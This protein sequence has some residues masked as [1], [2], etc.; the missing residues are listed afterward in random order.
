MRRR[1]PPDE[2]SRFREAKRA[3]FCL[4]VKEYKPLPAV[5]L[6]ALSSRRTTGRLS[7]GVRQD[8]QG[9]HYTK[10]LT[11]RFQ[12]Q[13]VGMIQ[14][15]PYIRTGTVFESHIDI[16]ENCRMEVVRVVQLQYPGERQ[17]SLVSV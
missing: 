6:M 12:V 15:L 17:A 8:N 3:Q 4:A 11:H 5:E 2:T 9:A 16:P 13:Q 14:V 1:R 7:V 10:V